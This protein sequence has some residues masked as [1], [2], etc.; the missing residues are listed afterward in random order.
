MKTILEPV[1]RQIGAKIQSIR[2]TLGWT[3]H[4]LAKKVRLT[5]ASIANIEA[6][7]Q[8]LLLHNVSDF[9]QAFGVEPKVLLRGIWTAFVACALSVH[10]DCLPD[11]PLALAAF[12]PIPPPGYVGIEVIRVVVQWADSR[13]ERS[14]TVERAPWTGAGWGPYVTLAVLPRNTTWFQDTNPIGLCL[15]RVSANNQCGSRSSVFVYEP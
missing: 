7:N 8:R 5:R 9:A 11:A 1:Y 10:A 13:T 3:Q 4:D 15:Y 12:V 6:G 14:Y 2:E